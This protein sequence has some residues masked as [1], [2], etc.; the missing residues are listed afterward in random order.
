MKEEWYGG[1]GSA[2]SGDAIFGGLFDH[3]LE[4]P[5]TDLTQSTPNRQSGGARDEE[6]EEGDHYAW[7]AANLP[8][9]S[10]PISKTWKS[11]GNGD[12]EVKTG[13][14]VAWSTIAVKAKRESKNRSFEPDCN[15]NRE[16]KK[17]Q[18]KERG[19]RPRANDDAQNSLHRS[20][21]VSPAPAYNPVEDPIFHDIPIKTAEDIIFVHDSFSLESIP[22]SKASIFRLGRKSA[23]DMSAD[24]VAYK[25]VAER[26][27]RKRV[28]FILKNEG[29]ALERMREM[30]RYDRLAN[31]D[32]TGL[33]LK[34]FGETAAGE[35]SSAKK[36][37]SGVAFAA[38]IARQQ[39]ISARKQDSPGENIH[40][41]RTFD[42]RKG[43]QVTSREQESLLDY[44][45]RNDGNDGKNDLK[46]NR[47][48]IIKL[49]T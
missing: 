45:N 9:L 32:A 46:S 13:G 15:R 5:R 10:R 33:K 8:E 11:V 18:G 48:S 27:L 4:R 20:S 47:S 19:S 17:K 36:E 12:E 7:L 43:F 14:K 1:R 28:G 24:A 26:E 16:K 22:D 39:A 34:P 21:G 38:R 35:Q 6:R 41:Y 29:K 44:L 3:L 42:P 31:T 23:Q 2:E 25:A 30:R 49:S 37:W 40:S